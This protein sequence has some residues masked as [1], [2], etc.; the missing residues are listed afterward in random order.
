M[1]TYIEE[2]IDNF[3][4]INDIKRY[5]LIKKNNAHVIQLLKNELKDETIINIVAK[6]PTATY[7]DNAH[8]INQ[9][10]IFTNKKYVYF[11]DIHSLFGIEQ[12]IK[13]MKY[14]F[15]PDYPHFNCR[16][17][18]NVTYIH[19]LKYLKKYNFTG[20]VFIFK[21]HTSKSNLLSSYAMGYMNTST[22]V[23]IKIIRKFCKINIPIHTYGFKIGRGYH[24]DLN[25]KVYRNKYE[26]R[27]K[28]Y[29]WVGSECNLSETFCIS[30]CNKLEKFYIHFNL[31]KPRSVPI[32]SKRLFL[33]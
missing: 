6:G 22:M 16:S 2:L 28:S 26:E 24:K 21:L 29:L 32:K 31:I 4:S 18:P 20:N 17:H 12:Y 1:T 7:I 8:A 23:P 13:D 14:I 15:F 19:V 10:A 33:H 5:K 11:N 25:E 9:G 30:V 3:D 27:K